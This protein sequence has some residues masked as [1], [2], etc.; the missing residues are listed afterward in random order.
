MQEG[1]SV[2]F[3]SSF[4]KTFLKTVSAYANYGDGEILFGVD[5]DG[6]IVGVDNPTD[7]CL[8]IENSINDAIKPLPSYS[9]TNKKMHGK[10]IVCLRVAQGADTPYYASNK[11]Y[12]RSHTST[13]EIDTLELNRLILKGL[14]TSFE[15]SPAKDQK[16]T[17]ETLAKALMQKLEISDVDDKVYKTLGLYTSAN[18]FNNAAAVLADV[19]VFPGIDIVRFGK[20]TN[21]F[22]ARRTTDHVSALTLYDEAIDM[23][24]TYYKFESVSAFS[25]EEGYSVPAMAYREAVANA[26]IH[27]QWDV[28]G[29][30][31]V[32]FYDDKIEICSP[33]GLPADVSEEDYLAGRLSVL[34]NPII[35]DV[36]AKL[37][38]AERFGTGIPRIRASYEGMGLSPRFHVTSSSITVILPS[39]TAMQNV[40]DAERLVLEFLA[41]HG[42]STRLEI[43]KSLKTNKSKVNRILS[44]LKSKKLIEIEGSGRSTHYK[45]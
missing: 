45:L 27:R 8:R 31:R 23:F 7:L 24:N 41:K 38:Y 35:T 21:E 19:N 37:G 17:F 13:I 25:R 20:S 44:E 33:G 43:E 9:L 18:G 28:H 5:D 32:S 15:E 16:L 30:V 42:S 1:P 11:A 12:K 10:E 29:A 34:R 4:S 40:S 2:E 26:L 3:K 14:N 36:F 6:S 22:L 39:M